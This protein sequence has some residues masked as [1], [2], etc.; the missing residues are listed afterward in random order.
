[1]MYD[2]KLRFCVW[3]GDTPKVN[4][5]GLVDTVSA[6]KLMAFFSRVNLESLLKAEGID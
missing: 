2:A 6:E 3:A 5:E 1:M 4:L